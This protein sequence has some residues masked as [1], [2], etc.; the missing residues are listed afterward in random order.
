[1]IVGLY[2]VVAAF[3]TACEANVRGS[4]PLNSGLLFDKLGEVYTYSRDSVRVDFE[5]SSVPVALEEYK[6]GLID[7]FISDV[8]LGGDKLDPFNGI[9]IPMMGTPLVMAYNLEPWL[10]ANETL[11]MDGYTM[12]MIWLGRIVTWNDSAIAA[13]NPTIAHKLPHLNITLSYWSPS[14]NALGFT[15]VFKQALSV[16]SPEVAQELQANGNELEL[17][18]PMLDG[19]GVTGPP[20]EVGQWRIDYVKANPGCMGYMERNAADEIDLTYIHMVNRAGRVVE[21]SP[22]AVQAAMDDH[23]DQIHSGQLVFEI[24]DAPGDDSWPMS[25]VSYITL[26]RSRTGQSQLDCSRV[27]ELL[28]FL[29]WVETNDGVDKLFESVA[30][31]PLTNPYK[32]RLIDEMYKIT[33]DGRPAL[34]TPVLIGMGEPFF[35]FTSWAEAFTSTSFSMKYFHATDGSATKQE[36][37]FRDI[38]YGVSS[39]ALSPAQ[40]ALVPDAQGVAA[41]AYALVPAYN[42]PEVAT[43]AS[44]VLDLE[45]LAGIFLNTTVRWNDPRIAQLNPGAT[46][47]DALIVPVLECGGSSDIRAVF[48]KALAAAVP[49]FAAAVQA[50][51]DAVL[52]VESD[53]RTVCSD[54]TPGSLSSLHYSFAIWPSPQLFID[55]RDVK[56]AR[57]VNSAQNVV[58]A[59]DSSVRAAIASDPGQASDP[60]GALVLSPGA[61]SWPIA[62]YNQFQVYTRD[63]ND[64]SKAKAL[65][66]WI[67]W[68]QSAPEAASLASTYAVVVVG[69]ASEVLQRRMLLFLDDFTCDGQHV[70]Q[71]HGCVTADGQLCSYHGTCQANTGGGGGGSG[72]GA[73]QAC[74]CDEGWTGA[75]CDRPSSSGGSSSD[76]SVVAIALGVALPVG[77]FVL[78]LVLATVVMALLLLRK[79]DHRSLDEFTIDFEELEIGEQL[80]QGGFGAVHRAVWKGTEVAVKVM[81][82]DVVTKE[83]TRAFTDEVEIMSRLRHP[84][85]VLFMAASVKPPR[86][87]I[88]MEHMALGSLYDVRPPLDLHAGTFSPFSFLFF[89]LLCLSFLCFSFLFLILIILLRF[90]IFF[91][92]SF[93]LMSQSD[94]SSSSSTAAAAAQ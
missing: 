36:L 20:F 58:A 4:G 7:F 68:T 12:A 26:S 50:G 9:Q 57:M 6:D 65:V 47:P 17:L 42:V 32:R 81:S 14:K 16:F 29:S 52:P 33:C 94:Y 92:V 76:D 39:S 88:V 37:A 78:C 56:Q 31:A 86:L 25:F 46:L 1:L 73:G 61:A 62:A 66:D 3:M 93:N 80:G 34:S 51:P 59:S 23:R 87:C 40:Q 55:A 83:S 2:L 19:R 13:F 91:S 21:G 54:D 74:A 89:A 18:P 77:A 43:A 71:I 84:N 53:P 27:Q 24:L 72:G 48:T 11:V 30:F 28:L 75:L 70:S 82:S 38:D 10:E 49:A 5:A 22:S 44:L 69:A 90:I 79:K 63:M 64:C 60:Y 85:V 67:Y 45:V 15:A 8:P 35:V 41:I